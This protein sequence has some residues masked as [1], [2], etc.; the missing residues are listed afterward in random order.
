M[1]FAQA[2][3]DWQLQFGRHGLPWQNTRDP[4]KIWLS[5][6]MLQ[7]TQV[8]TVIPYFLRFLEACPTVVDLAQLP[9]DRLMALW[10]GLGYYSRA[11]HLHACA[12]QI[13]ERFEGQFPQSAA[14]LQTLPGIGRSTAAAIASLAFGQPE[15]ILDGNVKRVFARHFGITGSPSSSLVLK[16]LWAIAQEQ[17]PAEK[18]DTYNQGLMDLGAG[19]CSLRKPL[20]NQCPVHKTC[21]AQ[22]HQL[23]QALPSPKP[24]KLTPTR[25]EVFLLV[26]SARKLLLQRQPDQGI[27]GGLFSLPKLVVEDA[28]AGSLTDLIFNQFGLVVSE[29]VKREGFKH[30]F[31]H[32]KLE[33]TVMECEVLVPHSWGVNEQTHQDFFSAAQLSQIGL[34]SPIQKYLSR[35][36][37]GD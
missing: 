1:Q 19:I 13:V 37:W 3:I 32:Y 18:A 2:V 11:R 17:V 28:T 7:Q 27:W 30:A 23:Q 4:Y 14:T 26:R 20:C 36:G 9:T 31:T 8:A 10:A 24:K 29:P 5:E 33:A 34:P 6:V 22:Q 12:Q 15:P 25:V 16:Q 21:F 35:L